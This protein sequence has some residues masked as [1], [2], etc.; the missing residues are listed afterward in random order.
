[1]NYATLNAILIARRIHHICI[2]TLDT[3]IIIRNHNNRLRH[4]YQFLSYANKNPGAVNRLHRI[5]NNERYT[6]LFDLHTKCN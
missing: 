4:Y 5:V 2:R 1:M 6:R 3:P